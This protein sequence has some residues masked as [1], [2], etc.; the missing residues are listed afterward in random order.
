MSLAESLVVCKRVL[1]GGMQEKMQQRNAQTDGRDTVEVVVDPSAGPSAWVDAVRGA[2]REERGAHQ[3]D[4]PSN[5]AV[6]VRKCLKEVHEAQL[7][8]NSYEGRALSQALQT[9]QRDNPDWE[10]HL[11]IHD[12]AHK[13]C[14]VVFNAEPDG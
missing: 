9:T 13:F 6:R 1:D 7:R 2:I 10:T 11:A 3:V 4:R 8:F 12:A 14:L 5:Y